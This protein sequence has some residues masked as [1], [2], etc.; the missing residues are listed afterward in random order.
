TLNAAD[1][2]FSFVNGVLAVGKTIPVISWSN[3][4]DIVYGTELSST[5]LNATAS[6]PT[7]NA[8]VAGAFTYPPTARTV[9]HVGNGQAL[10]VN[11]APSDT[12][13]YIAPNQKTVSINVTKA[14]LTITAN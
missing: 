7:T 2:S 9:L 1:Y 4:A 13:N 5:Q 12:T 14:T 10:A 8:N 11:F 3:P 6:D